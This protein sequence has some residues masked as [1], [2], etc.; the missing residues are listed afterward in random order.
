ML[1]KL[2]L[3]S[4]LFLLALPLS[5]ATYTIDNGH[6]E[7]AFQIRHLVTKVRGQF[8]NFEGT[9]QFDPNNW[10]DS[11]VE[12]TIQAASINTFHEERDK[13]LRSAD[14]FDVEKFPT[15]TF[16]SKKFKKKGDVYNVVGDLNMHG[17][18]KEVTLPVRF[19]GEATDPW[20][21]SKAGFET[22]IMLDR[23]DYGISWNAALDQGGFILGDDVRVIINLE[24]ARQ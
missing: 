14:F 17:V 11:S 22:E 5:A 19:L 15:I 6:S 24:V 4:V 20:G 16:K 10:K 12:F 23:Q 3:T 13:H 9:I 2:V 8:D 7:T 1:R 21:N 18:T